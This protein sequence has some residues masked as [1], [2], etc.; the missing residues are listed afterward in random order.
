MC[1][2]E[3]RILGVTTITAGYRISL[4]RDVRRV[5]E[6][7]YKREIKEG[8]KIVYVLLKN[9]AVLIRLA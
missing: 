9:G 3:E 1:M 7:K 2:P 4:I 6:T 8:E 5:L